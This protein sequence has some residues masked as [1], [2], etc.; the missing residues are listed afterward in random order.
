M[1]AEVEG[2]NLRALQVG[3]DWRWE[4][5]TEYLDHIAAS[6]YGVNVGA[7][8]LCALDFFV[9]DGRLTAH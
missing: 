1:F 8:V 7:M 5:F 4:S 6:K 2:V 3:I 9:E